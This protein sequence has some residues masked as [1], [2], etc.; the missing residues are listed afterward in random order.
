MEEWQNLIVLARLLFRNTSIEKIQ[1]KRRVI[2]YGT[3]PIVMLLQQEE[4]KVLQV[5]RIHDFLYC[6][7]I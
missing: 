4:V 6:D 1:G 5:H 3:Y 7:A 2:F